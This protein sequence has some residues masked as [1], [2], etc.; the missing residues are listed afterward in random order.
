MHTSTHTHKH[1]VVV[2]GGT[3]NFQRTFFC[4][5]SRSIPVLELAI[6]YDRDTWNITRADYVITQIFVYVL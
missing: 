5:Q 6:L 4:Q 2:A 3:H 1:K